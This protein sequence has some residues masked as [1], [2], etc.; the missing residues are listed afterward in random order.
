MLNI[1]LEGYRNQS[2]QF[3]KF[4]YENQRLKST[5]KEINQVLNSNPVLKEMFNQ[6]KKNNIVVA[7]Q[8]RQL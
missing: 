4:L 1:Y 3:D 5:L 2:K 8:Y 7:K 6:Q